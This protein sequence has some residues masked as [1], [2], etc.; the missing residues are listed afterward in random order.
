MP[1]PSAAEVDMQQLA[2]LH[3]MP[4]GDRHLGQARL[5][6]PGLEFLRWHRRQLLPTGRFLF[7]YAVV[8]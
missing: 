5:L 3:D 1:R 8:G 7:R 6:Q 2:V 4:C